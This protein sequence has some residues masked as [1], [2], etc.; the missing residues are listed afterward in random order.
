MQFPFLAKSGLNT[1]ASERFKL[2]SEDGVVT[3]HSAVKALVR[4]MLVKHAEYVVTK[5]ML[6]AAN[7]QTNE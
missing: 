4:D 1:F 5:R 6:E 2:A 7:E 3:W